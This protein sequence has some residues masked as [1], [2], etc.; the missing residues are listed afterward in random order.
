MT[1]FI[2]NGDDL[3]S[4]RYNKLNNITH[5]YHN[6]ILENKYYYDYSGKLDKEINYLQE[7]YIKYKY[8]NVGNILSKEMYDLHDYNLINKNS[9]RYQN[10][11]WENQLTKFND[12]NISYDEIGNPLTIGS[13]IQLNWINGRELGS[14]SNGVTQVSYKYNVNG[15]RISKVVDTLETKYYLEDSDIV[16]EQTGNNMLYYL[17]NNVDGLFGFKYNENIYYY[18]KNI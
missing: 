17:R 4:Y 11:E 1:K 14:Y 18:I 5:I 16:F 13:N 15:I 10:N 6:G 2:K 12:I 7:I 8:D 9:Y 3:Y